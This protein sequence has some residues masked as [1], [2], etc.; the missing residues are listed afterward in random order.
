M[1][2]YKLIKNNIENSYILKIGDFGLSRNY[3]KS[4]NEDNK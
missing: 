2:Y 1:D 4:I 3:E